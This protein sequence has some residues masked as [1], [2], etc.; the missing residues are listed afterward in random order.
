LTILA[1]DFVLRTI[2]LTILTTDFVL[3]TLDLTIV[4]LQMPNMYPIT[5]SDKNY[6]IGQVLAAREQNK[7][8]MYT[9]S[10]IV[11]IFEAE[12]NQYVTV[13]WQESLL[14]YEEAQAAF[15]KNHLAT[16]CA[17]L[18]LTDSMRHFYELTWADTTERLR[19]FAS[20]ATPTVSNMIEQARID[21]HDAIAARAPLISGH[22]EAMAVMQCIEDRRNRIILERARQEE[23]DR[24]K[25]ISLAVSAAIA[26]AKVNLARAP[27]DREVRRHDSARKEKRKKKRKRLKPNGS[28]RVRT[29]EFNIPLSQARRLNLGQPAV[30]V[31]PEMSEVMYMFSGQRVS[32]DDSKGEEAVDSW[33]SRMGNLSRGILAQDQGWHL[34]CDEALSPE[35]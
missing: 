24:T 23:A 4:C 32:A 8:P 20:F 7:A 9:P 19:D 13:D 35:Y 3:R 21:R 2:D 12:G 6:N 30:P 34:E 5:R 11:K 27:I 14:T 10:R 29:V 26:E 33:P 16:K 31:P 28:R 25:A 1:T 17:R 22:A 15:V 18:Y